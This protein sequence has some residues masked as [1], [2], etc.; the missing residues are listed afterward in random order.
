MKIIS[1]NKFAEEAGY[2]AEGARNFGGAIENPR[3]FTENFKALDKQHKGVYAFLA[4]HPSADDSVA[5]YVGDNSLGDDA[6]PN[7][8]ALF[9]V[10]PHAPRRPRPVKPEDLRFGVALSTTEHPAYEL[11]RRFFSG[12][13][14][15]RLPGIVFFDRLSKKGSSLYVLI[16]ASDK[17]QVR[18]QCRKAFEAANRSM[19]TA[20]KTPRVDFDRLAAR[21]LEADLSYRRQGRK[22]IRAAAFITTAWM[23]KNGGAIAVAIPK[24]L[25][26]AA[27][28]AVGGT[29]K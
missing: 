6:G 12:K 18:S 15:P 20:K 17:S 13:T 27:K 25:E 21:L 7:I 11:A 5:Q 24:F 19:T 22:G 3:T 2:I 14:P 28:M 29:P 8:L 9:L 4:F 10:Q 26:V 23:K 16:Q 1:L